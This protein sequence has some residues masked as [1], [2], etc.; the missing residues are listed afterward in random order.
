MVSNVSERKNGKENRERSKG[1]S[2]VRVC[3]TL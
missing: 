3:K 1:D 2:I